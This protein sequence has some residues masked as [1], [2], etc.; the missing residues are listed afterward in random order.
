MGAGSRLRVAIIGTGNIGTDLMFKVERSPLLELA[1]VAGIDPSSPGMRLARE[2][3]HPVSD[4]GLAGLLDLVQDID[5]AFDATSVRTHIEHAR[6]L[7]ERGIRSVDLTPAALGPA[8]V[9]PVNL[10]AY[11]DAAEITLV[12]CGAQ[13]TVPIV[14]AVSR[15]AEL[16]Y[17]ETVSTVASRSAG[18]GTRNNIDEFTTATARSLEQIGGAAKAK[19]IIILNPADPPIQMRN[20][21][22]LDVGDRISLDA[23]TATVTAAAARRR[24]L[25]PRLPARRG[26]AAGGRHR[27][28]HG[29]GRG[30]RGLPARL[31]RQPGHHDLGRRPRGRTLRGRTG[32]GGMR[33]P[34]GRGAAWTPSEPTVRGDAW[35]EERG[36]SE[37]EGRGAAWT[38]ERSDEG[39]RYVDAPRGLSGRQSLR[40]VDTTLRD[41]SHAIAHQF[42]VDQ[43]TTIAG[44]LDRAG[45]WAIAVGH[46][47]GLGANSLQYGRPLHTD[48]ELLSAAAAVRQQAEIAIAILPG[49][50]TKE[51]LERAR[52]AGATVA[53][54]STVVTEADI[55]VQHLGLARELGMT[56]HS[57]LN[58]AHLL[59]PDGLVEQCKIVADAGSTGIFIVDSAGAL[60]TDDVRRRVAAMRAALPED[61]A[62]G[63]H[64][65]NNLSLGVANTVAAIQEGA[66]LVDVSLAG[67]GPAAATA[68]PRR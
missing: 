53:R 15:V 42:T 51:D 55:G 40:I 30:R 31:R 1:G 28:R 29:R 24:G 8:I 10:T 49:I 47:D 63:M 16:P 61:V 36:P 33:E 13:A 20:T 32:D 62:I 25:R 60:L 64:E 22:Y 45:V 54:V 11:P 7:A 4:T 52:A 19:A 18:P 41:G 67:L 27:H 66:T 50:G 5:L 58:T 26:T 12:T 6:V 37:P 57:H 9:P 59:D 43:V 23:L 39:R 56:A 2:R 35:T 3:G 46:G 34:E 48:E 17:A 44:A 68:R 21:I 38:E 14:A 65:H